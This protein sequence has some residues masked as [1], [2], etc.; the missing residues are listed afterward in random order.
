MFPEPC[1]R[2]PECSSTALGSGWGLIQTPGLVPKLAP[3]LTGVQGLSH[4]LM[5]ELILTPQL[6]LDQVM[7]LLPFSA[8]TSSKPRGG[9]G[10]G[11]S[12]G[13]CTTS[14]C[15]VCARK[16]SSSKPGSGAGARSGTN[17]GASL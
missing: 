14:S 3:E 2:R 10:F 15:Q 8:G 5:S 9:P 1:Q 6:T 7:E 16:S 11:A 17:G 12:S 4:E 13:A